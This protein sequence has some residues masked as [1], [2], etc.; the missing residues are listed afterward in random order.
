MG[1]ECLCSLTSIWHSLHP[2][3][4]RMHA[5]CGARTHRWWSCLLLRIHALVIVL[6]G[7]LVPHLLN[8]YSHMP[9]RSCRF[10]AGLRESPGGGGGG[11]VQT[12]FAFFFLFLFDFFGFRIFDGCEENWQQVLR[13]QSQISQRRLA[14][15]SLLFQRWT[16][17]FISSIT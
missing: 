3:A 13:Y 2:V 16:S 1:R 9:C 17:L 15:Y 14:R 10:E 6:R 7:L 4:P 5:K 11:C 8:L 12:C